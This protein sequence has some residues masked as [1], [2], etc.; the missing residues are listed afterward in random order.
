MIWSWTSR[1]RFLSWVKM[2][3]SIHS[4]RRVHLGGGR[5]A[6]AGDFQIRAAQNEDLDEFV[7]DDPIGNAWPV[8]SPRVGV[9]V[10]VGS[11]RR[12]GSTGVP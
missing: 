10:G 2:P 1:H 8:A 4:S 12:T 7:E 11:A 6:G 3:A 9:D 5:A